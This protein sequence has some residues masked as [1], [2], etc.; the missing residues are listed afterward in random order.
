MNQLNADSFP[1]SW[2]VNNKDVKAIWR[3]DHLSET[4]KYFVGTYLCQIIVRNPFLLYRQIEEVTF[5]CIHD[6]SSN[7]TTQECQIF[8]C[9]EILEKVL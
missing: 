9:T 8:Y 4:K 7:T 2:R 3:F 6:L 1:V 5:F